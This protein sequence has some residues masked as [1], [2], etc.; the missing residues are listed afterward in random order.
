VDFSWQKT[1]VAEDKI[2]G[3]NAL[4]NE[5]STGADET[6]PSLS[7]RFVGRKKQGRFESGLIVNS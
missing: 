5:G 7:L 6:L 4:E 2:E 1:A 3:V